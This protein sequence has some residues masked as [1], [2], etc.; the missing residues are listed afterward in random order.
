MQTNVEAGFYLLIFD[1]DHSSWKTS[2]TTT[3][4]SAATRIPQSAT[5]FGKS[6]PGSS[7]Q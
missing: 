2:A 1:F 3:L 5:R 4:V 7:A 6:A